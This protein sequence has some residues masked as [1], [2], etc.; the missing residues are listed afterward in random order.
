VKAT[1]RR[2]IKFNLGNYEMYEVE[3]GIEYDTDE[4]DH[5]DAD[6]IL[7]DMMHEDVARG[8]DATSYKKSDNETS[9]YEWNRL[10][11]GN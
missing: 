3:A 7:D 9:I 10:I 8:R 4:L 5:D 6:K 2:S 1:R 11:G